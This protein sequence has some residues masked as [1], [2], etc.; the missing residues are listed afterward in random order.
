MP[1]SGGSRAARLN[2][3]VRL[4]ENVEAA[5]FLASLLSFRN[6]F[7]VFYWA[8][9]TWRIPMLLLLGVWRRAFE[10]FPLRYDPLCWGRSF[11]GA[12]RRSP[13]GRWPLRSIFFGLVS[14]LAGR[15]FPRRA[16]CCSCAGSPCAREWGVGEVNV[17][18]CGE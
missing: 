11:R 4:I 12:C 17:I 15:L 5:P 1:A 7:T 3:R 8:T 13:P 2:A 14:G 9:G 10:R 6:G 18:G 16:W